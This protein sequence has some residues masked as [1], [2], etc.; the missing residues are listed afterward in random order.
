M[1][2]SCSATSVSRGQIY[3]W[4]IFRHT[5]YTVQRIVVGLHSQRG[6]Y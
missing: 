1:W 2:A 4:A 3:D 6:P 5:A